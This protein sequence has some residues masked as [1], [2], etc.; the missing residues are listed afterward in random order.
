M[1]FSDVTKDQISRGNVALYLPKYSINHL[2]IIGITDKAICIQLNNSSWV[3]K[4]IK[5]V[6]LP[7]SQ[8]DVQKTFKTANFADSDP[9]NDKDMCIYFQVDLPDWLLRKNKII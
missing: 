9:T 4:S 5:N 7:I 2:P 8:I 3:H 1:N 6:W